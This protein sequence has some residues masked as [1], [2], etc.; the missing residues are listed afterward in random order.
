MQERQRIDVMGCP[1][2]PLTMEQTLQRV[3][4]LIADGGPHQ[5]MAVNANKL[6]MMH[7][8]PEL[9]R[10][11]RES[12]LINADG[13]GVVLASRFL[14]HPLPARVTG[15]DLFDH[16]MGLC[17]DEGYRPFL[18]GAKQEVLERCANNVLAR[19][20]GLELAGM[21]NGYFTEEEERLVAEQ[22]RESKADMLFVAISSP[23]KEKFLG[24]W[25]EQ[26]RVPF[27][28]GVGGTFDVF[29]G[30]TPRAPEWVQQAHMEWAFRLAQEPRRMW[31]RYL[32][33]NTKFAVR[34]MQARYLGYRIPDG[35]VHGGHGS[36]ARVPR[37]GSHA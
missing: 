21:R 15:V 9:A 31:K 3:R 37:A 10:V 11:V 8:D 14:G 19:Y 17:R 28:M 6:V 23:K 7:S 25:L 27:C 34:L 24:T 33:S 16:L 30:K 12:S 36:S 32:V 4:E 20:P 5:H 26:M 35:R 29:A 2:D 13:S 18:L 1:V 22:I